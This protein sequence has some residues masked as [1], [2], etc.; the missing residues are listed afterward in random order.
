MN[1]TEEAADGRVDEEMLAEILDLMTGGDAPPLVELFLQETRTR[2]DGLRDAL[3][4]ADMA[5]AGRLAHSLKG[6][7]ASFGARHLSN[8]GS[9]AELAAARGDMGTITRLVPV[10]ETEFVAFCDIL[11]ARAG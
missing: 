10:I 1:S 3:G 7:T 6:A 4:A 8:L 9:E 2:I 11:L 5:E